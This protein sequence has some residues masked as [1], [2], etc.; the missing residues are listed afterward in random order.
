MSNPRKLTWLIAHEPVELFQRTVVAFAEE[1]DKVLPGQFEIKALT[2]P[3]YV[4]IHPELNVLNTINGG[5]LTR[6][7][8]AT[9]ALFTA[10]N[11]DIDLSQTQTHIVAMKNPLFHLLDIPYLFTDHDHVNRVLDGD[12]GVDLCS[13]L[14]KTSDF[15][16]LGFTYS[17]GYRVV[18]SNH[19]INNI[20]EL[21]EQKVLVATHLG[22]R[23]KTFEVFGSTTVPVSPHLW[24]GYDN[25]YEGT[26]ATAIDTTYL[27]F[28]G[29][30]ILKTNHSLFI[31]TIL[32][33]K[34]FWTTLSNEQQDAFT[35]I[36]KTVAIIEREWAIEE[37]AKFEKKFKNNGVEFTELDTA[38]D[39]IMK[40]MCKKK[41]HS[42]YQNHKGFKPFMA[43]IQNS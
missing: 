12:I 7:D 19:K 26:G 34:K 32:S 27:R 40:Y 38:S 22:P 2:V 11:D 3:E 9:E 14:E 37:S 35:K 28:K 21:G 43:R 23:T 41:V 10:L 16:A 29:T 18:G 8:I 24:A 17:G 13:N 42:F 4:D 15:K 30:H 33:S 25:I 39:K 1:L 6:R 20:K 36:V 31:T 5:D